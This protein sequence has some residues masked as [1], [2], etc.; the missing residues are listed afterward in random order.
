MS[1]AFLWEGRL[2]PL[3]TYL[4]PHEASLVGTG[5][6][7]G[8]T[9]MLLTHRMGWQ[10]CTFRSLKHTFHTC[11]PLAAAQVVRVREALSLAYD[12]HAG[13]KRRSGEP[14]I[15]HPVEVAR[16]LAE[17]RMDHESLVA[18]TKCFGQERGE[19]PWG[20]CCQPRLCSRLPGFVTGDASFALHG[21]CRP[22]RCSVWSHSG[23]Y[24]VA[25]PSPLESVVCAQDLAP[26]PPLHPFTG[27]LHDTVE[28]CG[29]VVGLDEIGFHFGPGVRRIV[30]GETKFSKLPTRPAEAGEGGL[31]AAAALRPPGSSG[32]DSRAEDMRFLFL[33][34]TEEV[35]IIIVKLADRLHNMRTM[36]SMPGPKQT[37]IAR[38]TL[39]VGKEGGG[40]E[41]EAG[42]WNGA[43]GGQGG[44][45]LAWG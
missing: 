40:G 1:E 23:K 13:Q 27:L 26:F 15:T 39:Q 32:G 38:E 11:K 29:D 14:Y 42:V 12:A 24:A 18:G 6:G 9:H 2:A 41:V 31:G 22:P 33:A 19:W 25:P 4:P 35:R 7:G 36:R 28:D 3:L 21:S 45:G 8:G 43:D 34:M 37:R 16:I 17:L 30:E 20:P 5:Q 10:C 44:Y